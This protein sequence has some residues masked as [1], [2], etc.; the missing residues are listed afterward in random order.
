METEQQ[1]DERGLSG[2]VGAEQARVAGMQLDIEGVER[3]QG[4]ELHRE[5][6]GDDDWHVGHHA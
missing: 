6:L 3:P 2:A 5:A 4:T 1:S